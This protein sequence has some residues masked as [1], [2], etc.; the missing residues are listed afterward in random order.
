MESKQPA[1]PLQGDQP[2]NSQQN[3]KKPLTG[4]QRRA[5]RA[6]LDIRRGVP[7]EDV[8][9]IARASNGPGVIFQLRRRG[10]EIETELR[11]FVTSDGD[12]SRYG[13]YHLQ[14]QSRQELEELLRGQA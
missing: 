13:I 7:R 3:S 11:A 2:R 14:E 8:D 12:P 9:R 5:S 10:I 6:L 4:K 1:A